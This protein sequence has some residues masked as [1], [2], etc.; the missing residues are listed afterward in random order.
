MPRDRLTSALLRLR[1]SA[2]R[3]RRPDLPLTGYPVHTQVPLVDLL[4]D[5]QLSELNDI[6]PWSCFTVDGRGRRFGQAAWAGKRVEPQPVPDPR[7][8]RLHEAV[9]LRDKHVLEIGCFEGVHTIALAGIA[10]EVTAVDARVANVVKTIVRCAFYG[11]HAE[12]C[13]CNVESPNELA[14]L[15][16]DVVHHV[17]VL[18]HLRDPVRH[19]QGLA[20][21]CSTVFLDTHVA[22]EK[23]AVELLEVDGVR[24]PCRRYLEP[25][26]V[27]SG[28]GHEAHWLRLQD[29]RRILE[30]SGFPTVEVLEER[31][32]RNGPRALVLARKA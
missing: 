32:E 5:E 4:T 12:V 17:G 3:K 16:A 11:L 22:S 1:A 21:I 29:I 19:L 2:R 6:L 23:D 10:R 26:S 15:S 7:V 25:P 18:Y 24:Y 8:N 27:F 20:N 30:D 14:R 13:V 28:I 9:D 31:A